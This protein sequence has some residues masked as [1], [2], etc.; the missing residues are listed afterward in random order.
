MH[1]TGRHATHPPAPNAKLIAAAQGGAKTFLAISNV[2][3][4]VLRSHSLGHYDV[5]S[6]RL[7]RLAVAFPLQG[8]GLAG[9]L[10]LSAARRCIRASTEVGGTALLIDANNERVAS[11]YAGFRAMRLRDAPL[12]LV[13]P[14]STIARL[15]E[16]TGKL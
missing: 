10:L 8:L 4:A 11:W 12:C 2:D 7:A 1:R 15:L 6:F 5:P 13:L 3:N 16:E 9:Q 14:L